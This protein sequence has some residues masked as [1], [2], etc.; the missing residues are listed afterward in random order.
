MNSVFLLKL[1]DI[2]PSQLYISEKKLAKT[3][4]KFDPNDIESLEVIPVKKLGD[5]IIYTDGHT[6][7]YAAYLLG[8]KEV[9]VE[10]E[11]EDLDWEM[12]EICVDWCKQDGIY[13]IADLSSRVISHKEYETL[14]YER[15]NQLHKQME[16]KRRKTAA[17]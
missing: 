12:Y 10:W 4:K 13:S 7:A 15:C 5:D 9:K 2:Q 1:T 17:K 11:T 6:R 3:Q 8:W 14:W 16:E